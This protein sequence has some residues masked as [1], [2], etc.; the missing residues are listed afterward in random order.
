MFEFVKT[1]WLNQNK[2]IQNKRLPK[3]PIFKFQEKKYVND[4]YN[5]TILLENNYYEV[6][7]KSEN[8]LTYVFNDINLYSDKLYTSELKNSIFYDSDHYVCKIPHF[9]EKVY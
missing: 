5:Q 1:N 7:K 2:Y 6:L 4:A 9:Y 3:P 8:P